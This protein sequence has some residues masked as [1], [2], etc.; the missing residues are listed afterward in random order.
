MSRAESQGDIVVAGEAA[1][2]ALAKAEALAMTV[3]LKLP[4]KLVKDAQIGPTMGLR[5]AWVLTL[6]PEAAQHTF[7]DEASRFVESRLS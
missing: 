2:E 4:P 6:A 1:T 3:R 7:T 5:W